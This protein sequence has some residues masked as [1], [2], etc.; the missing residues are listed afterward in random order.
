MNNERYK[1]S[2][3][4][5]VY[6]VEKYIRRCL[7][8]LFKQTYKNIE[9]ILVDD[10]STDNSGVICD[11]YKI[12]DNRFKVIHQK[13]GGLPNARNVGIDN[14][15]GELVMFIDSDDWIDNDCI[16]KCVREFKLNDKLE[17]ILFPY[18]REFENISKLVYFLG[19]KEKIF[20]NNDVK[21][22]IHRRLFGPIK[23][24]LKKVELKNDLN[25][26]W[27]KIFLSRFIE[28]I[29]FTDVKYIGPAEDCYFNMQLFSKFK[30]VKYVPSIKY[31]YNKINQTSIVH[32]Y[33]KNLEKML[34]NLYMYAQLLID[35]NNYNSDY[36]EGLTNRIILDTLDLIRN[37]VN[38]NLTIYSKYELVRNILNNEYRKEKLKRFDISPLDLKWKIYYFLCKKRMT[39]GVM[40]MTFLAEILK[41]YLR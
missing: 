36:R 12:K 32:T 35:K 2:I 31:H 16:E 37:I 11:Q 28:N 9:F 34:N 18:T 1:V 14:I 19:E 27:G 23:E 33:N 38:S 15:T 3:I 30:V 40:G 7:D 29:R 17:C 20:I 26:A 10:G 21:Q 6:N 5:P 8:S 24:E 13:N 39:I 25:T 41:K 4:V 22:Y